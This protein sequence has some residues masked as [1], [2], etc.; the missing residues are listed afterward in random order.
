MI[1]VWNY[2]HLYTQLVKCFIQKICL[3]LIIIQN[4]INAP[5]SSKYFIIVHVVFIRHNCF[6]INFIHTFQLVKFKIFIYL[7]L[8][9]KNFI[10]VQFSSKILIHLGLSSMYMWKNIFH[11]ILMWHRDILRI[12]YS[13]HKNIPNIFIPT[14]KL[15]FIGSCSCSHACFVMLLFE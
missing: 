4:F 13:C 6:G 2:I 10:D 15:M 5:C 12:L 3:L 8:S 11:I 7:W 9:S 1:T 14:H